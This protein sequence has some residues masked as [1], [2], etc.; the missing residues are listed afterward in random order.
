MLDFAKAKKERNILHTI[1][2]RKASWI[3]H[4]LCRSVIG[5]KTGKG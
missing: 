5:G 1:K 4:I 3:G 2:I